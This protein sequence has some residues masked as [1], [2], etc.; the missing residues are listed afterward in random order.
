MV[1]LLKTCITK[2]FVKKTKTGKAVF[3][4]FKNTLIVKSLKLVLQTNNA[5]NTYYLRYYLSL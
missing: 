2:N 4:D 5:K 3:S 1:Y